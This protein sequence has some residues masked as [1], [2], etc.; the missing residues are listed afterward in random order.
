MKR[1]LLPLLLLSW[2][3]PA[4]AQ[5]WKFSASAE[6]STGKYGGSTRVDSVYL[7]FTLKQYFRNTDLSLTVPFVRQ[8]SS[9][10][11]TSVGGRPVRA[12]RHVSGAA[13]TSGGAESGLG[14]ILARGTYHV[15]EDGPGSFDF[16]LGGKLKF[17]TANEKRG[18]G[19]GQL[20]Q[21]AGFE[22][23]KA[24]N[25]RWT[26]LADGWYTI[27][28]DP[29]GVDYNNQLSLS[30]G[31]YKPLREGLGL[32]V[33]YETSSALVDGAAD[34]RSL[35]ATLGR[36]GRAGLAYNCGLS[37]GLSEGSPDLA[38]SAGLSQSF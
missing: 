1:F 7:P 35:S 13:R 33:S 29:D 2:A 5:D 6:Y 24:L 22:F 10:Q 20:D 30:L 11:V 18:L 32:T 21:G 19:T 16:A 12:L 28:G 25:P 9:G 37:L 36:K 17:P 15:K 3:P 27:I 14:D 31:F 4:P 23:G 8:S 34:P 38:V 26:L